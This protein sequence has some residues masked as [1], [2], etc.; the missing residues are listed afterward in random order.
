MN[1]VD[2]SGWMEYFEEKKDLEIVAVMRTAK[3]IALDDQTAFSAASLSHRFKLPMVDSIILATAQEHQATGWTMDV[4]FKETIE[5]FFI[6][7]GHP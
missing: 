7:K 2:F 3:V 6:P 5:R 1:I 4:Y